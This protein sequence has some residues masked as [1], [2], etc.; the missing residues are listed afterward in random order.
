MI[1]TIALATLTTFVA[2][3]SPSFLAALRDIILDKSKETAADKGKELILKK[4]DVYFRQLFHLDEKEQIRHLDQALKNAIERGLAAFNTLQERD[5]YGSILQTLYQDGPQ[6]EALRKEA[7]QLFT[8]S[9]TPDFSLLSNKYNLS[10]RI[11]AAAQDTTHKNIDITPYLTSFFNALIAE[12]YANPYFK[13]QL[14]DT[15]KLRALQN[16]QQ[17]LLQ[18]VTILRQINAQ[19][20]GDYSAE[21]FAEDVEKYT[22]HV[23][24]TLHYLKIVGIT[25]RD[26]KEDPELDGI[27]VPLR[28]DPQHEE[29]HVTDEGASRT[30]RLKPM[31]LT[32]ALERYPCLVLLGGPGLGKSTAIRHLAWSHAKANRSS[33]STSHLSLL[34]GHPLPLRI[35]LRLF[36]SERK[37]RNYNFLS[38][39]T[40]VLLGREG[41]E[42]NPQMFK[43]LLTRR[44]M[45]LLFDGLDEIATL[46]ERSRLVAEIEHFAMSYPGNRVVIT[47]RPIGYELSRISHPQFSHAQ[48]EK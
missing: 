40:E 36:S 26:H 19:L 34:S 48:V 38:Y 42:I 24:R 30:I 7:R 25:L 31:S 1:E 4:G 17:S 21:Q 22:E 20:S 41:I 15:L 39:A 29:T 13:Q 32:E 18:V 12:L 8:F 11:S 3:R 2:Q 27:F 45:L 35:E 33:S 6:G 10:Q 16:M 37:Q 44:T 28:V 46:D 23:E 14:S 9:D 43:E 47:S 5:L